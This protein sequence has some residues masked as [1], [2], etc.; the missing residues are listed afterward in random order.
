MHWYS[1]LNV[2]AKFLVAFGTV[3]VLTIGLGVFAVTQMA[4]INTST[5]SIARYWMPRVDAAR[6]IRAATLELRIAQFRYMTDTTSDG[7][8]SVM[9]Q[10]TKATADLGLARQ[11]YESMMTTAADSAN[12]VK[13][14][15]RWNALLSQWS[16]LVAIKA[17]G[18]R[19]VAAAR[20]A[21]ESGPL[22]VA[23]D[24]AL[25]PLVKNDVEGATAAS[26]TADAVFKSSR[27]W[28]SLFALGSIAIGIVIALRLARRI[29]AT[30]AG[31]AHVA[32][33]LQANCIA[34]ARL[35]LEGM[36]RGDTS[37]KTVAVTKPLNITEPDELG[38]LARTFDRMIANMQGL[39][40]SVGVTQ[41]NVNA[42]VT[43]AL[44]FADG[45]RSGRLDSR[46]DVTQF[47][48]RFR[49]LVGALNGTL[50]AVAGPIGEV[51]QVMA[52]V[53]DRD[54]SVRMHGDYQGAYAIIKSSVNTAVENLDATL[55]QV[56]AA[57][58]HVTSAGSQI[59]SAAQSLANGSSSQVTSLEDVSASVHLFASMTQ[60]S[61]TNAA[62]ARSLA[63]SAR[64]DTVEGTARMERLTVAV[65]EMTKASAETA[66]IIK[67][68]D[69]IAF[70]TNLLALN[71]AVEAAR[72][73][74]AG[75]G[76]AVVAE[77]VRS[78]ALRAAEAARSTAGLIEQSQASAARGVT[79]N[80]EVMLSLSHIN[81]QIEKV[82]NVTAEISAATAQQVDA[83][84]H[85]KVA[86]D[87]INTVT[88]H[89][90]ANAEESASAATELESQA[91][92][93]R[94]TVGQ[95]TLVGH[96]TATPSRREGRPVSIG[97]G[98]PRRAAAFAGIS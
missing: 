59:T 34:S 30:I 41:Q 83:V 27:I 45:A 79:L 5:A 38:D 64:Q 8:Q 47:E 85:I 96:S 13:A 3:L 21:T 66:K 33:S 26:A 35:A 15:D 97:A 54:L 60:Q 10:L 69:E 36:A 63:A 42:V 51:E 44:E 70:Q 58:E 7:E 80:G 18:Q 50:D 19:D 53:A 17:A 29:L 48:G 88:Q 68:I 62:E 90:A 67:T 81:S 14:T 20:L 1:R 6:E 2:R 92:T 82:A 91:A 98:R 77:E 57:A 43:Q 32:T 89:V 39:I 56:N 23:L 61:A 12:Y 71:A 78:L 93:L 24:A 16:E 95:F 86:V 76:F 94:D 87:Q 84:A 65:E 11:R 72:A 22:F 49:E 52:K 75:R 46:A 74:D 55:V 73:G 9:A 37:V 4:R 25:L 31:L 28:V 40:A